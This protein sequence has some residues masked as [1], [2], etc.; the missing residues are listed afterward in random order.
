MHNLSKLWAL[1]ITSV[2]N[3]ALFGRKQFALGIGTGAALISSV[4]H[5]ILPGAIANTIAADGDVV[6]GVATFADSAAGSA[7]LFIGAAGFIIVGMILLGK[8]IDVYNGRTQMGE[9]IGFAIIGGLVLIAMVALI[10]VGAG[11]I[12]DTP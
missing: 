5:A 1:T 12:L 11:I 2:T 9:I 3:V 10:T 6:G 7:T 4:S 8:F